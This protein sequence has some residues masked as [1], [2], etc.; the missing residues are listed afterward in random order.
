M[1]APHVA[2]VAA[3]VIGSTCGMSN[4]QVITALEQGATKLGSPTPNTSFGYGRVDALGALQAAGV[5]IPAA[6]GPTPVALTVRAILPFVP[7]DRC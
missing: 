2:A 5:Q 1:A 3:L 6:T 7:F 4:S